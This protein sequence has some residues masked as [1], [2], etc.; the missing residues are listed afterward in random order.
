MLE[1]HLAD[2]GVKVTTLL[3]VAA[4]AIAFLFVLPSLASRQTKLF[5]RVW[6]TE[7]ARRTDPRYGAHQDEAICALIDRYGINAKADREALLSSVATLMAD[8]LKFDLTYQR[9]FGIE[10]VP[11]LA[12]EM[13]TRF[14]QIA[15]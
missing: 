7:R 14:P 5:R 2:V 10:V 13:K 3:I 15:S 6:S 4:A 8:A 12:R 1:A 11:V 9:N